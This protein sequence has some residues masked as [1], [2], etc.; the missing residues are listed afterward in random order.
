[1][2]DKHGCWLRLPENRTAYLHGLKRLQH[3]TVI[4]DS[5]RFTHHSV[6][7]HLDSL[8]QSHST[9][10]KNSL[11]QCILPSICSVSCTCDTKPYCSA[12]VSMVMITILAIWFMPFAQLKL[13][14]HCLTS[15]WTLT[16]ILLNILNLFACFIINTLNLQLSQSPL[17][18]KWTE[19]CYMLFY[20]IGAI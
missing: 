15:A 18:G 1:M 16:S 3:P 11:H 9:V 10:F 17:P 19:K 5:L 2:A 20:F 12:L 8:T 7:T 4:T 13:F 6:C 14:A